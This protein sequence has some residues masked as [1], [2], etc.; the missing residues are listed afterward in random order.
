MHSGNQLISDTAQKKFVDKLV[1]NFKDM[2]VNVLLNKKVQLSD[3]DKKVDRDIK[4]EPK[5]YTLSDGEL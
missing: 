4:I 2:K 3:E 1:Q 5:T